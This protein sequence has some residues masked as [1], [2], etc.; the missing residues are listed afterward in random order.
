[1]GIEAQNLILEDAAA[2]GNATDAIWSVVY[3]KVLPVNFTLFF[4][5]TSL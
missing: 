4:Q 1:M 3:G 5:P 2:L